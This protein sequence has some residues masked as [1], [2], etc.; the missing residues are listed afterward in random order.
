[1]SGWPT[2]P[3]KRAGALDDLSV[4]DGAEQRALFNQVGRPNGKT[5]FVP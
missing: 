5:A 3:R 4:K 2:F 1:M